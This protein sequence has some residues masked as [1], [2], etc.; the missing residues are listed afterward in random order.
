M[1]LWLSEPFP[2]PTKP[3]ERGK[4]L[5]AADIERLGQF[6]R[7]KDVDGDGVCNR[8]IPGTQHELAAYFTRG[9][10]HNDKSG[11]SERPED[12]KKNLDRI[13]RKHETA[14]QALPAP[15]IEGD[16]S[17]K[18]G[19]I[20][21]GGSHFAVVEARDLLRDEGI[22]TSY[23]RIRALPISDDVKHYIE[24]HL[25]VYVVE[26]N[27]DAQVTSILKST[28]SGALADRLVPITHYNGTPLAAQNIVRPILSWEKS[29]SG[30][31]WPTGD[32][33]QDNP[34]VAHEEETSAE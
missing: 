22:S 31:G 24:R 8:T 1:N 10:G 9:T 16:A 23:C 7:Y 13:A 12:W 25:R 17:T 30:P 20:A 15:V 26:Q 5:S 2:Y 27:R 14:R 33:E 18:V 28:L 19:L 34:P 4:V 6:E 11:Y 29:P 21:Y 3:L 32:V